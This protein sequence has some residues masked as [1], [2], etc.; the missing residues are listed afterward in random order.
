MG[1]LDRADQTL[2]CYSVARKRKKIS[3]KIFQRLLDEAT[4]NSFVLYQ[5]RRGTPS[6]LDNRLKLIDEII[7]KYCRNSGTKKKGLPG[8]TLNMKRCA[9]RHFPS[10][11][12]PTEKYQETTRR[13]VFC[14]T[15]R[16]RNGDNISNEIGIWSRWCETAL[17][18]VP[19]FERYHK[20]G[21]LT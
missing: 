9:E 4:Y 5:K 21:S 11:I 1:A 3:Y 15:N 7:A 13:C 8:R 19:C 18:A 20:D 2:S 17:C 14:Y 10:H 16:H 12:P 6:H